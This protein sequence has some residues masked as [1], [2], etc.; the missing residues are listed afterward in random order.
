MNNLKVSVLVLALLLASLDKPVFGQNEPP[1]APQPP[2]SPWQPP[3]CEQATDAAWNAFQA[4]Q[5]ESALT[6]AEQCIAAA[7]KVADQIQNTLD[8]EKAT[9]PK[10]AVSTPDKERI[11][12]YSVLHD[13]ATCFLIKGWAQEKLGHKEEARKAYTA[14]KKYQHARSSRPGGNSLWSP[15]EK[16]EERLANL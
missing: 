2:A 4:G 6:N 11:A 7:G 13:V 9:L 14:A 10:G 15:A 12:Q 16:A 1:P 8:A 3:R 5:Y